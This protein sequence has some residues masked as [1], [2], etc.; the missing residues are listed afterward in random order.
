MFYVVVWKGHLKGQFLLILS[1]HV[2]MTHTTAV[3]G[4]RNLRVFTSV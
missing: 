2:H 1:V 4:V 3:L